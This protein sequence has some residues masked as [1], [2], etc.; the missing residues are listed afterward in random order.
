MVLG[1][2]AVVCTS[3]ALAQGLLPVPDIS[4]TTVTAEVVS[5]PSSQYEYRYTI[6]IPATATGNVWL[7]EVD[8]SAEERGPIVGSERRYPIRDGVVRDSMRADA[9]KLAPFYGEKGSEVIV[10]NQIGPS[11]WNG[12]LTRQ[13]FVQFAAGNSA[14]AVQPGTSAS[15]FIL[16][17]ERPPTIRR[18]DVTPDWVLLVDDHDLVTDQ[19]IADGAAVTAS[20]ALSEFSLGPLDIDPGG[21]PHYSALATDISRAASIGWIDNPGLL[22]ELNARLSSARTNVRDGNNGLALADFQAM[23][24]AMTAADP[25]TLNAEFRALIELN[26]ERFIALLPD[27]NN[28]FIPVFEATPE[29]ANLL[30]GDTFTWTLRHF[31]SALEGNPPLEGLQIRIRCVEDYP[32]ANIDALT[33]EATFRIDATGQVE[34]SYV[35]ENAG[36]DLVEVVENDFEAFRR[37]AVAE[38]NWTAEADLVIPAFV[39]PVIGAMSGDTIFLTDRTENHGTIDVTVPTITRYFISSTDPIDVSTATVLGERTVPPLPVDGASESLEVPFT[40][41]AGFDDEMNYLAACADAEDIVVEADESNNCS[42]SELEILFDTAALIVDPDAAAPCSILQLGDDKV[43]MTGPPGGV[44]GNVCIGPEG[45]M[46]MSGEQYVDGTVRLADDAEFKQSGS[47]VVEDF[48]FDTDLSAEIANAQNLNAQAAALSCT[49]SFGKIKDS[50]E[51][52]GV[53]GLNVICVE[54]IEL[55]GEELITLAGN[56]DA[57]FVVNITG[58][59]FKLSGG[60]DIRVS[61]GSLPNQILFNVIGEGE[62]VAL[63]GGGGG[64]NCCESVVDGT[65]LAPD[66]KIK[67]SPG[68]VNGALISGEKITL[69]SGAATRSFPLSSDFLADL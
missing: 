26:V 64:E 24:D 9:N 69:S 5:I 50:I 22:A 34:F 1:A 46:S 44:V 57:N 31:N 7:V 66:R 41:P 8:V 67:L 49:Q 51:I 45:E 54:E 12:G 43:D 25:S 18:V 61:G 56:D 36:F 47:T 2:A 52:V 16:Q 38:I 30:R 60:S 40:I 19:E 65:I 27:F 39:P 11:G 42:F 37:L 68:L 6:D 58:R 29:R 35:G 20:L 23:L 53:S 17:S 21:Q 14:F 55:S 28:T 62:D 10:V 4:G 15:G 48:E 3:G 63:S 32:C 13:G 59:K 33:P